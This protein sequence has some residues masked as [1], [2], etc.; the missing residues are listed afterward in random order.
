VSPLPA[1]L[2][3]RTAPSC[4]RKRLSRVG[5]RA[6]AF[7]QGWYVVAA[8]FVITLLSFGSAYTFSAFFE[9]LQS[10]FGASRGS[11][12]LVF[13]LAG[14]VYFGLGAI[15]GPL[16]DRWGARRLAI[17]GM[18]LVGSG[19]LV[20]GIAESLVVIYAAYGLGVGLGI[21]CAYVPV[22]G[23]VQRWF[24]A[25]RGLASG[26]AVSGSGV[27]TLV[28]PLLATFLIKQFGWRDAYLVLGGLVVV[29]GVAAAWRVHDDPRKLGLQPQGD[30]SNV[31]GLVAGSSIREAITSKYF[32]QLYAACAVCAF[33]VF[34]PFVHLV[35]YAL[36]HG[37]D[38]SSAV[39]LI[40]AI[41]IGSTVGR[42]LLGGVADKVGRNEALLVMLVG[43]GAAHTLWA[44]SDGYATLVIFA[45]VFGVF[46]GGFVAVLPALIMD[47]FGGRNVGGIIGVLY[48]SIA[49]G[50]LVGP[51]A[52]GFAYD[53]TH[54]YQ[55]PIISGI[56][57]DLIAACIVGHVVGG[58]HRRRSSPSRVRRLVG[59]AAGA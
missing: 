33:S 5:P 32:L 44:L 57:A 27:G 4:R 14:F 22:L 34:V 3:A 9:V 15:S 26:L 12:S 8:A 35:P 18:C 38:H 54:S 59:S 43:M 25:R 10:T 41:G 13:S 16:A 40:G 1:E 53:L 6:T 30:T 21:G 52:A 24:V 7:F 28:M 47:R 20:A 39:F 36:D 19:L 17:A 58:I 51:T 23:A 55:L 31:S 29:L 49:L 56:A 50:T 48:T 46:Y 2:A 42:F 45:L 37:I 11:A